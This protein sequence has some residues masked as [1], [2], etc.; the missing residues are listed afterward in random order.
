MVRLLNSHGSLY[1]LNES[2][3]GWTSE[4]ARQ[5]HHR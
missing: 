4:A 1:V 2:P 5:G 3:S